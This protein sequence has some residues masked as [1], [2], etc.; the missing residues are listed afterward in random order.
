MR[1]ASRARQ[2]SEMQQDPSGA[3]EERAMSRWVR[4][5]DDAMYETDLKERIRPGFGHWGPCYLLT[6]VWNGRT[7]YKTIAA[8]NR[9]FKLA[10]Q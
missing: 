9:E 8:F 6:P 5:R 7:H 1:E 2:S 4:I 10:K 3:D